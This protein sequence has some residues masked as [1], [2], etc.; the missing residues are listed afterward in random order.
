MNSCIHSDFCGETE[1]LIVFCGI[2]APAIKPPNPPRSPPTSGA[3]NNAKKVPMVPIAA[4]AWMTF[5][6]DTSAVLTIIAARIRCTIDPPKRTNK[7]TH[8]QTVRNRAPLKFTLRMHVAHIKKSAKNQKQPAKKSIQ[9][10]NK[11]QHSVKTNGDENR[12]PEWVHD[13]LLTRGIF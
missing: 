1:M 5:G 3:F 6:F 8:T 4:P 10:R 11:I 9:H 2:N 13:D 7:R 12:F